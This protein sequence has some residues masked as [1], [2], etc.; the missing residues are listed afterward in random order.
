MKHEIVDNDDA[1]LKIVNETGE[2]DRTTEDLK[3]VYPYKIEKLEEAL[4]NSLGENDPKILK[5]QF[6]DNRRKYI[7]NYHILMNISIVLIIIRNLLII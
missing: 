4:L 6:P 1:N 5:T 7:R 3:E 2:E